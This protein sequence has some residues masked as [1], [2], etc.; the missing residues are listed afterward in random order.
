MSQGSQLQRDQLN[1][2]AAPSSCTLAATPR[3]GSATRLSAAKRVST[4]RALSSSPGFALREAVAALLAGRYAPVMI[5][6][7]AL[8]LTRI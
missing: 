4:T 3:R 5:V 6:L 1:R 2:I 8:S 7:A